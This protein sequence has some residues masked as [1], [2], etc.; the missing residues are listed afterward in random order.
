MHI[1]PLLLGGVAS[2]LLGFQIVS[3]GLLAEM[4]AQKSDTSVPVAARTKK[5]SK[6][7]L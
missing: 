4:I 3:L 7:Q 5:N 2:I 1:R 6:T